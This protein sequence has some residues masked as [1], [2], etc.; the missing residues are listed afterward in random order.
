MNKQKEKISEVI[1]Q[2]RP[3]LISDGGNIELIKV[4]DNI[5]YIKLLGACS[6]CPMSKITLKN[7][8]EKAIIEEVPEIK[9]VI[10]IN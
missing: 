6:G 10:E 2:I 9:E 1:E 8:V 4:E 7:L 5:V 3:F